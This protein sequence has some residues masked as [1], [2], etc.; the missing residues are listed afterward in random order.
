MHL[1]ERT[2]ATGLRAQDMRRA[3]IK[4]IWQGLGIGFAVG[5]YLLVAAPLASTVSAQPGVTHV[6]SDAKKAEREAKKAEKAQA[7]AA[8]K[9]E[10]SSRS[11]KDEDEL[12]KAKSS[13]SKGGQVDL[14]DNDPLE[15]L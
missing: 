10:K 9:K 3:G 15:G 11:H 2:R 8:K 5:T 14:G 4:P 1:F 13:K 7:R 12:A 6:A